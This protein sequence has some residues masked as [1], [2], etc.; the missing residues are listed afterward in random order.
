VHKEQAL[1]EGGPP[2]PRTR[3][4]LVDDTLASSSSS[5]GSGAERVTTVFPRQ[6][7]YAAGSRADRVYPGAE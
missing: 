3:Y 5:S 6:G 4:V 7:H 2:T 1:D